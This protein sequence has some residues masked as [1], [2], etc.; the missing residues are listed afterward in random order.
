MMSLRNGEGP[1]LKHFV[2][3]PEDRF[4]FGSE[5]EPVKSFVVE[6]TRL[7]YPGAKHTWLCD[8]KVLRLEKSGEDADTES[9]FAEVWGRG[10]PVVV[11]D[12]TARL[13]AELWQPGCF[14]RKEI[15]IVAESVLEKYKVIGTSVP[16]FLLPEN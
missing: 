3:S 9:L 10:Q 8:G 7:L 15:P 1:A 6:E 14:A 11:G 4:D 2:R 5:M 13:D 16:R 12:V